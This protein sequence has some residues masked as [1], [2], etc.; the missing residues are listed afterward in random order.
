MFPGLGLFAAQKKKK[1]EVYISTIPPT[2]QEGSNP[3]FYTRQMALQSQRTP[4][5]EWV[6]I[7]PP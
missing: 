6:S 7:T 1:M 5:K 3:D 4:P 2:P